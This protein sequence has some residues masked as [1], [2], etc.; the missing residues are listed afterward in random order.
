MHSSTRDIK[1]NWYRSTCLTLFDLNHRLIRVIISNR[2]CFILLIFLG[3]GKPVFPPKSVVGGV[4]AVRGS[5]PWYALITTDADKGYKSAVIIDRLCG[6][7][8]ISEEWVVTSARCVYS[9][10]KKSIKVR[11]V[12]RVSMSICEYLYTVEKSVCEYLWVSVYCRVRVSVSIF[13]LLKRASA[14]I[15]EYL[16]IAE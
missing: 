16:Y 9:K 2:Y 8:L 13:I 7:A 6:G 4:D 14:S 11:Y 10:E 15:Y 3:C 12:E 1:S 5:W